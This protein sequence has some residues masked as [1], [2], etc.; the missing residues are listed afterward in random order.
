MEQVKNNSS[1]KINFLTIGSNITCWAAQHPLTPHYYDI[2]WV[3]S[4][5]YLYDVTCEALVDTH[6]T[7]MMCMRDVTLSV[8]E[9]E[10][11]QEVWWKAI[12]EEIKLIERNQT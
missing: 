11:K 12:G 4:F 5:F 6:S 7:N 10:R 2:V 3:M 8:F 9:E 1:Q